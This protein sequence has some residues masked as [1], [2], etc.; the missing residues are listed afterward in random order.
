VANSGAGVGVEGTTSSTTAAAAGVS[1]T[2]TGSSGATYGVYGSDG[3]ATGIGGYFTNTNGGYALV[4]GSGNVGIGTPTPQFPLHIYSSS[5]SPVLY[6]EGVGGNAPYIFMG[7]ANAGFTAASNG[8]YLGYMTFKGWDG[9]AFQ[10]GATI[11]VDA[12]ATVSSGSMP[13]RIVFLTSSSGSGNPS[14]RMR[15]NYSGVLGIGTTT[16]SSSNKL[17]VNGAASIGYPDT[18]APSNGMIVSGNRPLA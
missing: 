16:M 4:T 5:A 9:S 13:G 6:Q 17:E 11:R 2:A 10:A 12:D 8:N 3:S 14:E 15:L 1:G 18:A 7:Y